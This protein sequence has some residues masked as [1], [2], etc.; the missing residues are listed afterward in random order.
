MPDTQDTTTTVDDQATGAEGQAPDDV[1][2]T[3]TGTDTT[4]TGT[5]TG[6]APDDTAADTTWDGDFDK[7]RAARLVAALRTERD[8]HKT[9]RQEAEE[10]RAKAEADAAAALA[11]AVKAARAEETARIAKA[12]GLAPAEEAELTPEQVIA[13]LQEERDAA[14]AARET[15][16]K[17]YGELALEVAVQDAANMHDAKADRLLDSRTFMKAVSALDPKA[18]GYRVAVA[19]AVEAAVAADAGLKATPKVTPPAVSGGNT[20]AG[21]QA[22]RPEDMT[23]DELRA[24]KLHKRS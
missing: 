12:L 14:Q 7:D 1:D 3:G 19:A 11:E 20:V 5:G 23:I 9:R 21:Q 17:A 10:A 6:T 24:A 2:A 13:K 15:E 18:D 4:T 22:K 8:S 16:A